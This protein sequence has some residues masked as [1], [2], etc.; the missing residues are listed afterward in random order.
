MDALSRIKNWRW[1]KP[2]NEDALYF[3][4]VFSCCFFLSL[5]QSC[6]HKFRKWLSMAPLPIKREDDSIDQ[7]DTQEGPYARVVACAYIPDK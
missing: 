3:Q 5:Q 1:G 6:V 7:E 4:D 2:G